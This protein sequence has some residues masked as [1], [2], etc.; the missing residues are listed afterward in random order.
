M[1]LTNEVIHKQKG[2]RL[3]I[4][5]TE[6]YK[7]NTIV[8]KMKAPLS[9]DTVT[10]RGLLPHVLQSSSNA[11]PTTTKLRSY[12]DE[13]YGAHFFVDV[14][15][16]GEQ[17]VMSFSIELANEKFLKDQ[18]PLLE[19]AIAFLKEILLQPLLEDGAFHKETVQKEK[20]KST[21][22]DRVYL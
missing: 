11:Y 19:K 22:T 15:K 20:R 3:H 4:V 16:K 5:K 13:L 21:A 8:W 1:T 7:T 14:G 17:H 18:T 9:E 10:L 2:Y 12:L 6:K